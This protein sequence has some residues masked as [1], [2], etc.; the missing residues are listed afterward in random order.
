MGLVDIQ[1]LL[2]HLNNNNNLSITD[3]KVIFFDGII[4]IF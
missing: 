4:D 3:E 1:V 2:S